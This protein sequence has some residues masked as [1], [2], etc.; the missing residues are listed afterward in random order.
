[1]TN[2][3]DV[4]TQKITFEV[5]KTSSH[6]TLVQ[7]LNFGNTTEAVTGAPNM[8]NWAPNWDFLDFLSRITKLMKIKRKNTTF[9]EGC[10]PPL[11]L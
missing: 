2:S 10:Y 3:I 1:M 9:E 6:D 7:I 11:T 8:V 4:R 5:K